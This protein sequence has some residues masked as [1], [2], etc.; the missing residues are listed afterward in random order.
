VLLLIEPMETVVGV[1]F[2]ILDK[3]WEKV[4]EKFGEKL[5]DQGTTL[6]QRIRS[7]SP[8]TVIAIEQAKE[9]PLNFGQA[10]LEV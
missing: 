9:V 1:L 4:A 5:L 8:K 10:V 6:L 2:V 3:A 7:K